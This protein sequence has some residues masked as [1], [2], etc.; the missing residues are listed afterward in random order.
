[1]RILVADDHPLVRST[2]CTLL[3]TRGDWSV[4]GEAG[5]GPEAIEKA[6]KLRPDLI[7]M[8]ISMPGMDGVQA[9]AIL[10]REVPA[11]KVI[12]VSQNDPRI[13]GRQARA[14]GAAD[15]VSKHDLASKLIPRIAAL[16]TPTSR[17]SSVNGDENME[18]TGSNLV[19]NSARPDAAPV[20]AV[21]CTEEL[22]R[23]PARPPDY[24]L[25]NRALNTLARAL[26]DSPQTIL[27]T[28]AET[29][30][31][32][33][34][35]GSAGLSLLSTD[36]GGQRFDWPAIA[37]QWK[38]HIGGSNPR[39]FSPCG[40]VLDRNTSLL[41]CR[42]ERHYHYFQPV[43]P[44]VV[45]A[46]L[47]P[48][49]VQ[50]KAMGTIWVVAHD[51]QRKFDAEDERMMRSL[52]CFVSSAYQLLAM[53]ES[54]R[55]EAADRANAVI[56]KNLLAA[57]VDSSDDAIVSKN[58]DGIITSWNKGAQ[59]MF[60]HTEAEA[61]GQ[62]IFLLI[63]EERRG[64][65]YKILGQIARG[66]PVDHFETVRRR[67]DG[68][69]LEVSLS[70]SP[71]RDVQGK[72]IGASK[73]AR[74][75][76]TAKNS[77][78]I[79]RES[80]ERF[81]TLADA[82]ET[83]VQFRTRELL[84]R[85]EEVHQQSEQLRK[86]S[87]R[88]LRSQDEERRRIARELHDSAGQLVAALSMTVAGLERFAKENPAHAQMLTDT[89]DLL[90][91]LNREIRTT[92]YLLHP[93]LLDESGLPQAIQWYVRGLAE[94]SGLEIDIFISEE[95]GRLSSDLELT[96]FRIVQES[97]T[98][99]HRHSESKTA[100]IRL[101]RERG[102]VRLGIRDY[103]KG[104]STRETAAGLVPGRGGV[105][106]TGMRERVRHFNGQMEIESGPEGTTITVVF[107]LNLLPDT[108]MP[109]VGAAD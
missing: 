72:I 19:E 45:E 1:M 4:C 6:K 64:E 9:T 102:Q 31:E 52:A 8:D 25:E 83:Q 94:R 63:P 74:D 61:V 76:T 96:L 40:V 29:L 35:A 81:R 84:H 62:H 38:P 49:Y 28:F 34:R 30:M 109:S 106:I 55:I 90:Q 44:P 21:L 33:C 95:F 16:A 107:P 5:T 105:G 69:L 60:G 54:S 11:S 37:G 77:E 103:G 71:I 97:L 47:V 70:I 79:L 73:I 42:V 26:A 51:E 32:V 7:L 24:A 53:L 87:T 68:S 86:L 15:F 59:R 48:F 3:A 23:R 46:L 100:T 93:P 10:R 27:Q 56:G 104:F 80:E 85:N 17:D 65:E 91:Q 82:L 99:I 20:E 98:N 50:G 12:I 41:F 22:R 36:D 58:L 2:I 67:K 43:Q 88:L 18:P 101:D 78:R 14:A 39:N 57:I 66:E 92:S 89:Q 75:I 108:L 13:V